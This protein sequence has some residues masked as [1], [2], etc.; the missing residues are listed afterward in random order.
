MDIDFMVQDSF[1]LTRPQWKLITNFEEAGKLFANLVKQ[2]FKSQGPQ[3]AGKPQ[4]PEPAEDVESSSDED[5]GEDAPVPEMDDGQESSDEAEAEVSPQSQ[6]DSCMPYL[7]LCSRQVTET[8][9]TTRIS[10]EI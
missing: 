2:H 10:K 7:Y 4:E 6:A 1:A 9:S 5:E 3:G 8:Q